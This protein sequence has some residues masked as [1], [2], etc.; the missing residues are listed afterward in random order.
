MLPFGYKSRKKKALL[1][2]LIKINKFME[3]FLIKHMSKI[4]FLLWVIIFLTWL[5]PLINLPTCWIINTIFWIDQV[6]QIIS[7]EYM[8]TTL[9]AIF[10]FWYW[11]KRYERDKELELIEKYTQIYESSKN[12]N[13]KL[14]I[15]WEK[16]F[17]LNNRWYISNEL[18]KEWDFW[19]RDDI[20]KNIYTNN[21]LKNNTIIYDFIK[22]YK[23]YHYN[24]YKWKTFPKYI[25]SILENF[26]KINKKNEK[27]DNLLNYIEKEI[28]K[29]KKI[30]KSQKNKNDNR[31]KML[32][33]KII[34]NLKLWK[35]L[36]K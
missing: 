36:T 33:K 17:Y 7:T 3:K 26:I 21:I 27:N 15:L 8:F 31:I 25:I 6:K 19:I 24:L 30:G 10:A 2:I 35:N 18:W 4:I 9:W 28:E 20:I 11:Y 14:L 13:K 16:E 22:D 29:I 32:I 34:N 23:L 12:D 5:I 1:K